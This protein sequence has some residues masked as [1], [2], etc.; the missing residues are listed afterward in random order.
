MAFTAYGKT[1]GNKHHRWSDL[2]G[3]AAVEVNDNTLTELAQL[4]E[5]WL[6]IGHQLGFYPARP[7]DPSRRCSKKAGMLEATCLWVEVDE[8]MTVEQQLALYRE[9]EHQYGVTFT[10]VDTGNKSVHAYLALDEPVPVDQF[11]RVVTAFFSSFF[12]PPL[13][14]NFRIKFVK[15]S[16]KSGILLG[17]TLNPKKCIGEKVRRIPINVETK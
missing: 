17:I 11:S 2:E 8:G 1:Q 6:G 16:G 14:P 4:Q 9:F 7:I 10:L 5:R 3:A 13:I 12:H 15:E